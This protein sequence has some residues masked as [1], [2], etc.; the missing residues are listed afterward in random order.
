MEMEG[1]ITFNEVGIFEGV[2]FLG[3][4]TFFKRLKSCSGSYSSSSSSGWDEEPQQ[5]AWL[6]PT[7][8]DILVSSIDVHLQW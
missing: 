3:S 6:E 2:D 4:P 5:N 8:S 1:R 7:F